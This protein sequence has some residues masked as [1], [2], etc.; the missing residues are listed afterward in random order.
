MCS[1]WSIGLK[2]GMAEL[3]DALNMKKK[4]SH[5]LGPETSADISITLKLP[6][7]GRFFTNSFV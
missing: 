5:D 3:K 7:K 6:Q 4:F 1:K 2:F